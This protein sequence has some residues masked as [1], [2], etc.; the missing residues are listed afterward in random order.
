ML[1]YLLILSGR[2][3]VCD[4]NAN[5]VFQFPCHMAQ[6][7]KVI[8]PHVVNQYV[9]AHCSD[10]YLFGLCLG[11]YESYPYYLSIDKQ[12]LALFN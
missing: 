2:F 4:I 10:F 6:T 3:D 1:I 9:Q 11:I 12:Y 7:Q 5:Q 8:H